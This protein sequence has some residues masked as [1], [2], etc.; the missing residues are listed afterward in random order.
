MIATY[1]ASISRTKV[2]KNNYAKP[3]ALDKDPTLSRAWV[4]IAKAWYW[5]ADAY[6]KPL[7]AYQAVESA[8]TKALELNEKDADA[9][10]YLSDAKRVL[11]WDWKIA[12]RELQRAI[13]IDPN[14]A[15]AHLLFAHHR[16]CL[17]DL[18]GGQIEL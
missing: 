16:L 4:G 17:G 7:Q 1:K 9:H 10:A 15:M 6:L 18:A 5:L 8:A 14:S 3:L 13:E 2:M 11:H 12:E